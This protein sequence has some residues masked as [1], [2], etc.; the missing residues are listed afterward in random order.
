MIANF[1]AADVPDQSGKVFFITGA[2]T[3]IGFE[4]ATV[5]AAR[6]ARVLLGC[7]SRERAEDAVA[8]LTGTYAAADV[9]IVDVDLGDLN[10]VRSAAGRVAQESRLDGFIANA[11]VMYATRRTTAD[12]FEAVLGVNHFGHFALTGLLLPTL[13][14][15]QGARIVVIS[16]QAHRDGRIDFDDID[17]VV[18]YSVRR[19]YSQSKLANLLFMYELDRRLR[20]RRSSTIVVA[21]HP[22]GAMTELTRHLSA[23]VRRVAMPLFNPFFNSVPEGAWPTLAAATH[24]DVDGGQYFGPDGLYQ[25]SG[26]AQQVDSS[27]RS[28][29][30]VVAGRLWDLSVEMTGVDPG[31]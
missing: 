10:S 6:G 1:T 2:N 27:R 26:R 21:A 5:L 16:S 29:D 30:P 3:G 22:G 24:P 15:T 20:A 28:K 18:S 23:F 19:R 8:R 11:G 4:A 7:R 13:E 17:A 9:S 14:R 25:M 31:V 12:G